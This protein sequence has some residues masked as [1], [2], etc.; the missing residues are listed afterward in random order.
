MEHQEAWDIC[1]PQLRP[2]SLFVRFVHCHTSGDS[3][4]F[5]CSAVTL[6]PISNDQ[7]ETLAHGNMRYACAL[8]VTHSQ[9]T[10]GGQHTTE[11]LVSQYLEV[12]EQ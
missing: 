8:H 5:V 3:F 1:K 10:N 9:K 12:G 4:L 6:M 11:D 7:N 2:C